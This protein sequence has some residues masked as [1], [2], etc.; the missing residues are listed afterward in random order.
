MSW[1]TAARGC[2]SCEPCRGRNSSCWFSSAWPPPPLPGGSS[3]ALCSSLPALQGKAACAEAALSSAGGTG[4]TSCGRSAVPSSGYRCSSLSR[5]SAC[6]SAAAGPPAPDPDPP[7]PPPRHP[8]RG[9]PACSPER[10][11]RGSP[12]QHTTCPSL[13]R[14]PLGPGAAPPRYRRYHRRSHRPR[15]CPPAADRLQAAGTSSRARPWL[16]RE[17]FCPHSQGCSG[18]TPSPS[19]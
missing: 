9:R 1:R 14:S 12:S 4:G 18:T 13:G 17:S 8:P 7:R 5:A 2:A 19:P 10:C 6:G 11:R 15:R 16:C 3:R